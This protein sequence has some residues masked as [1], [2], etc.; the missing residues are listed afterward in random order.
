MHIPLLHVNAPILFN[1]F[2]DTIV[3]SFELAVS[4]LGIKWAYK[5]DGNLRDVINPSLEGISWILMYAD[6]IALITESEDTMR[7]AIYI[8]H[9][10]FRKWGLHINGFI[11]I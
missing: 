2:I 7:A 5:I 6:D 8:V 9:E 11:Y 4:Q 10:A 1:V 3:R